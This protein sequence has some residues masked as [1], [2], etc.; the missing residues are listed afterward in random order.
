ML[1]AASRNCTDRLTGSNRSLSEPTE[2]SA[3]SN[4]IGGRQSPFASRGSPNLDQ[5]P[6]GDIE[7]PVG[8]LVQLLSSLQQAEQPGFDA[9]RAMLRHGVQLADL[10]AMSVNGQLALQFVDQIQCRNRVL[11]RR[12][13]LPRVKQHLKL[14]GHG[15]APDLHQVRSC[16]SRRLAP[17]AGVRLDRFDRSSEITARPGP[18]IFLARNRGVSSAWVCLASVRIPPRG[19]HVHGPRSTTSH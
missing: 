1:T 3:R 7:R 2:L 12:R 17:G 11:G 4:R 8:L 19:R 10:A 14:T 9:D 18:R 13:M 5:R 15:P 16:F 6:R